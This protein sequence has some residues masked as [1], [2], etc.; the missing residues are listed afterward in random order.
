MRIEKYKGSQ[1]WAVYDMNNELIYV[2]VYKKGAMHVMQ[3]IQS[4]I[5]QKE[6]L[7]NV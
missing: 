4:L 2:T 1:H 6:V 3:L 5:Q 7:G